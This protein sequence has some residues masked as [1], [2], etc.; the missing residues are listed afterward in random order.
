MKACVIGSKSHAPSTMKIFEALK[1]IGEFKSVSFV[2]TEGIRI[3]IKNGESL[4]KYRDKDL[5]DFD[6]VVPRIGASKSAFGY[7]IVKYLRR[8]GV[9]V[10][11]T[12]ECVLIAHDKYLTLEVLNQH[13]IPI[14]ETYLTISP[15]AA[16]RT[17]E[18]LKPPIVLKLLGGAG[19]KGVMF[20]N[21]TNTAN[22]IIDTLGV[23]N[24]PLFL[25]KYIRNPGEDIRIIVVGDEAVASMKRIAKK[26]EKRANI[27]AGGKGVPYKP[28]DEMEKLAIMSARAI[29]AEI[30]GIDML[31]TD[32]GPVV[33]EANISPG[34]KIANITGIDV[35]KRIAAYVAEK[36]EEHKMTGF[37]RISYIL[38]RELERIPKLFRDIFL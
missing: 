18:I 1:E 27:A 4:I 8:A 3:G 9:Y 2:P 24:Q 26:G 11:L 16:K 31:E 25:E 13:G 10:P 22:T 29:G 32:K 12:P 33:I 19:G 7:L 34:M 5:S 17:I 30:C 35:P 15:S 21:D 38:E 14:P 6:A 37:R 28:T 20:A 23:L 36:A